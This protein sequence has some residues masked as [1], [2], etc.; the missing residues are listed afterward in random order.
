VFWL[1]L[2]S[3][4]CK[5]FSV[6]ISLSFEIVILIIWVNYLSQKPIIFSF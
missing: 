2:F 3:E 4:I 1:Q 6:T 5:S